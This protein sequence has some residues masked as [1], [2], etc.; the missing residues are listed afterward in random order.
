MAKGRDRNSSFFFKS[1]SK[2]RSRNRLVSITRVDGSIVNS[3]EEVKQEAI[4]F[5]QSLLVCSVGED[6]SRRD[7]LNRLVSNPLD[8]ILTDSLCANFTP[9][10][11]K[12][13]CF[14]KHPNKSLGLDGY[15]GCFFFQRVWSVTGNDV[16]AVVQEFFSLR[17]SSY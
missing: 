8:Y 15:N 14:S 2:N 7:G 9:D 17:S 5:F 1:I 11:N 12:S 6:S 16:I 13:V 3:E 4:N 10:D